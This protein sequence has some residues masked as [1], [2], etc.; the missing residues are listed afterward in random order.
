MRLDEEKDEK[1]DNAYQPQDLIVPESLS[2]RNKRSQLKSQLHK[3]YERMASMT[4]GRCGDP[5]GRP[6]RCCKPEF[7]EMTAQYAR[8]VYNLQLHRTKH[9]DLPFMGQ[10]GCTVAPYLRPHCTVYVCEKH[11]EEDP[12]FKVN[13]QW[14]RDQ[15]DRI[16]LDL[17]GISKDDPW[18]V[19][20]AASNVLRRQMRGTRP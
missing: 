12:E 2:D 18:S 3:Q 19:P 5:C 11:L 1:D 7:C 4:R 17:H 20:G 9:P 15:I 14:L 16:E 6:G 13:Y 10:Y 8:E